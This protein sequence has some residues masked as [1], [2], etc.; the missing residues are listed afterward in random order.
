M[1]KLTYA[2]LIS[3]TLLLLTGCQTRPASTLETPTQ[4]PDPA[5]ALPSTGDQEIP[6]TREDVP[7][8][9]PEELRE[10]LSS[11]RNVVVIDTRSQ[12][13]YDGGHIPGARY[14][15]PT[16]FETRYRDLP[17]DTPIILYCA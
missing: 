15:T 2:A 3:L 11:A 5:V 13:V 7:R 12:K 16:E 10:L 9:T 1:S 6:V 4:P 8:I 17:K 14:I